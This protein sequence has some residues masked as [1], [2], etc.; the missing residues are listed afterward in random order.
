[1]MAARSN[2]LRY[3]MLLLD[4]GGTMLGFH[5][6][7]PFQ[8]FL[9]AVG[10]PATDNDARELHR[11]FVNVVVAERDRAEGLGANEA[12]LFDWWHGI[13]QKVWPER[14]DLAE[15]MYR[16]FRDSRFDRLFA[17]TVPA[18]EALKTLGIRLGVVSNFGLNLDGLLRRWQVR[19]YFEFVVISA[20]VGVAKPD[21]RIFEHALAAAGLAARRDRLLYV[22]DHYG[23]D[24]VGA[25]AGE[26]DAV[27]VD[28]AGRHGD[29]ACPR[30]A[31][32]LD[33]PAY[34][35]PPPANRRGVILDMDGVVLN[36][37]P[38][39]LRTWQQVLAPLG[40]HITAA[41]LYPLEGMPTE[42]T[43]QAFT[44][45]FL[46][47]PCSAAEACCLAEA[48]RALFLAEFEPTFIPGIVPLLHD[49]R[50]R[51]HRLALAT[52]SSSVVVEHMLAPSGVLALFDRVI[53]GSQ[54][55]RGKP[56]PEP[57]LAA[58]S[59][60]GL[61]PAECLAVEN[62]PLGIQA[63]RAAGLECAALETSLPAEHLAAANRIFP[64]VAALR[65]WL[66]P[67]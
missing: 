23:D 51:G 1:M 67:H 59:A 20:V 12:P 40:I 35:Q 16:S 44:E 42:P 56:D 53:T 2:T 54:V 39:H 30:I 19:D 4:V 33:L 25:R 65:T 62:S 45:R 18:L 58:I 7:A 3:D 11:R 26:L 6:R 63:A 15:A 31:S 24:V 22:G 52:G 49:L 37:M 55:E 46:G 47:R 13:F 27:L 34:I 9:A 50:G 61:S 28:R 29:L 14:P 57:F 41:D 5:E 36:S 17:D 10:L 66:I 48:K 60:L 8:E 43:A 38:A 32:L 64:D 21:P